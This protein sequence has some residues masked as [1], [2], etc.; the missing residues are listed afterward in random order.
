MGINSQKRKFYV[1]CKKHFFPTRVSA[2][3]QT[4]LEKQK[5]CS[6]RGPW[7]LPFYKIVG[8]T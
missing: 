7:S 2:I 6:K 8:E 3:P 4:D 1:N 5:V